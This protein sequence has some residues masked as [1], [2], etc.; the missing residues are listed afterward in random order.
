MKAHD[1]ALMEK[2]SAQLDQDLQ[3]LDGHTAS[4]LNRIRQAALEQALVQKQ[5]RSWLRPLYALASCAAVA[6]ALSLMWRVPEAPVAPVQAVDDFELLAGA[7][8]LEMI[9][10]LEFYAWLEQQS[11]DG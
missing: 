8:D 2:I 9:E 6:L 5:R 10:N 3:T 7:E 11:L 1:E 4:R